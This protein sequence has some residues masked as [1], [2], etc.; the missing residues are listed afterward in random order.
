MIQLQYTI[1]YSYIRMLRYS[2]TFDENKR[3]N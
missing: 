2:S 3:T 1:F